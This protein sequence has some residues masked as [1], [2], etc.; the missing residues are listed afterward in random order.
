M[1]PNKPVTPLKEALI[2]CKVM[3]KYI[4]ICGCVVNILALASPL[5]S[6]QVL[7]R[8]LSSGNLTTLG[9]L[10]L[11]ISFALLLLGLVQGARSFAMNKMGNWFEKKLSETVFTN[12]VKASLE[13][14]MHAN[15]QQ[16]RDLQTIK[17]Y[18]TSPAFITILDVPWA[19]IFI[20]VLFILHIYIGCLTI[21]G[22]SVLIVVSL[23]ADRST[24]PLMENNN[25]NFIKSMRYVDQT[26]RNSEV[27]EVMG[28]LPNVINSWQTLNH[29]VQNT[30]SLTVERQ[31]FFT[32]IIKFLR[33]VIQIA[34]TG[35]GAYLVVTTH[36]AF[37]AGGII[38][39]SS[40]VSRALAPFEVAITSWK[41]YVNCRKAYDRLNSG[42]LK[43]TRDED[44]MSLPEPVGEMEVENVYFAPPG[45]QK[46]II[47]GVNFN[48]KAGTMLAIIGPSGSG[49]TT[50]AKLLVGAN[51]PS[52]GA[53]RIDGASLKDWKKSELGLHIGYLPQDVELFSGTVRENIARMDSNADPE[54]V[55][56]SA[57][58]AG[59]HEMILQL[60]KAYDTEIGVDGSMLSGGQRQRIGLARAFYG[61]VKILVLDEPNSNLDA[62]GETALSIALEVAKE[63]KITT[64]IISHRTP[65]L[66]LADEILVMKDGMM[67]AHGPKKEILEQLNKAAVQQR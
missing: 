52:I 60:P 16:M 51:Q 31:A 62:G 20:I 22:G 56:M 26:T 43:I 6:L 33:A 38:A 48:L 63:K 14:K 61:D 64:I 37:S 32:E 25:D 3:L 13:S 65:V 1:D 19:I 50:L 36:G 35:V 40:L 12:S 45:M 54:M 42:F 5:Y 34:V 23:I 10:S 41:G 30:Q 58:L 39:S 11:V 21:I 18:L 27:V 15:S 17:T 29:K 44:L 47:K 9:M 2:A 67:A 53:V 49:K 55:I 8:V 66:N 57:Q 4:L 24:K 7:D 28:L 59:V 46:H